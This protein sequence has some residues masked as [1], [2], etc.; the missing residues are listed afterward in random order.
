MSDLALLGGTPVHQDP[1]P[2]GP[3]IDED[4]M[5]A[6]ARVLKSRNL[7]GFVGSPGEHH[8]GGPEV[9]TLEERWGSLG[10]YGGVV[11]VNSATAA[12]H[13]GVAAWELER[14]SEVIV[15]P[16]TMSATGAAVKMA[17]LDVRF[18]D[19]DPELFTLTRD[20]VE[21]ALT[22]RTS[23]VLV[24]HLFGQMAPM[25][26]LIELAERRGLKILEDAAQ[27]PGATQNG[28]WPGHGTTG[29]VFSFNQH[30]SITSGEGGLLVSDDARVVDIAR[31]IRNHG[32]SVVSA[33]PHIDG[34]DLIG[35][36][37][38]LTE[39]EAAIAASQSD[40]LVFL[41]DW[42]IRLAER[43]TGGI[44]GILGLRPPVVGEG[45]RH[46]YFTYPLTFDAGEW[47]IPR[48]VF[49]KALTAEG[50]PCVSGYA[51]PLYRLDLFKGDVDGRGNLRNC[52][53]TADESLV[54]IAACRWPVEEDQIDSVAEAIHKIWDRRAELAHY[55]DN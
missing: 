40:K 24:V 13:V 44:A 17:G 31:L 23:A 5:E 55:G 34:R 15:A 19:I 37:Y 54:L 33:Y 39:I 25:A 51:P 38:R 10:S 20:T 16:Y 52:D 50:V 42:R 47:G 43:L 32:E 48:E 11:A 27:A 28:A 7:S 46:V 12:L 21:A 45:N 53:H 49:V 41:T 9:R 22:D 2:G 6:A 14:G 8:L 4:E 18:A 30:K 3:M 29:A 26:D 36:N 1:L 35:W